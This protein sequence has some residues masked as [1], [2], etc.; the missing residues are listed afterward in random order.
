M[1]RSSTTTDLP[2]SAR[3]AAATDP[4][5][6]EPMT[7]ASTSS[8]RSSVSAF[9]L[10][11]RE[12]FPGTVVRIGVARFS[13]P[14]CRLPSAHG[15]RSDDSSRR[16]VE[17]V[18]PPGWPADDELPVAGWGDV[19]MPIDELWDAFTDVEHWPSWNR[20]SGAPESRA[21]RSAQ[22]AKLAWTFR[23]IKRWYPYVCRPGRRSSRSTAIAG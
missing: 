7:T 11:L 13:I 5:K 20:A 14:D 19:A 10:P 22:S 18:I 23:P 2:A 21:D 15:D 1:P 6:P 4:P 3:R 12:A 16:A 9:P 8:I 17:P